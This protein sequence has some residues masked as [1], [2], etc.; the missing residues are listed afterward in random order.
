VR[1]RAVVGSVLASAG[2]LVVGWQI[3]TVTTTGTATEEIPTGDDSTG[4]DPSTTP[5]PTTSPT[6]TAPSIDGTYTGPSVDARFGE[7]QVAVTITDGAISDVTALRVTDRDARSVELGNK[8]A[9]VLRERVIKS[10]SAD[11]RNVSGAT[12]SAKA[13]LSSLQAAL[14]EAGF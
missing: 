1:K 11:V 4:G 8:A 3:G 12:Y 6:P 10:Q 9:T 13:Y 2:I 5:T 7:M 14:D